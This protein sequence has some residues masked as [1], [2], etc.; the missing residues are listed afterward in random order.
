MAARCRGW[1][2]GGGAGI[3]VAVSVSWLRGRFSVGCA[4]MLRRCVSVGGLWLVRYRACFH[5]HHKIIHGRKEGKIGG[6][7]IGKLI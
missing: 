2:R 3:G 4:Q 1:A 7:H 5:G 6:E